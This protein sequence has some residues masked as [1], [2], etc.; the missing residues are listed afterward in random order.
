MY[1]IARIKKD[2]D[3]DRFDSC[4]GGRRSLTVLDQSWFSEITANPTILY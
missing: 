1:I 3:L 2:L 4:Q